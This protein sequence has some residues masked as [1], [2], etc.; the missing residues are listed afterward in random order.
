MNCKE[1]R[2]MGTYS[3]TKNNFCWRFPPQVISKTSGFFGSS[4]TDS[5]SSRHPIVE[6][7][8]YCGEFKAKDKGK[9]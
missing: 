1:C 2:F 8:D 4:W 3:D 5:D 6:P 7:D 9:P